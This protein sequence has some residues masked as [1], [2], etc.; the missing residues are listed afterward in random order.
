MLENYL[1][2]GS[3]TLRNILYKHANGL[4]EHQAI[5]AIMSVDEKNREDDIQQVEVSTEIKDNHKTE[6]DT[7]SV[8][9]TKTG[10]TVYFEKSF[11][12]NLN[13]AKEKFG[14]KIVYEFFKASAV[15]KTQAAVRIVLNDPMIS[16][17]VA[18]KAGLEYDPSLIHKRRSKKDPINQIANKIKSGELSQEGFI[19]ELKK[20]LAE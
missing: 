20:K 5:K 18:I 12:A 7:I 3:L 11:G 16:E 14:E 13:E 2:K 10:R 8:T 9:S 4:E 15:I 17:E 19:A 1:E 6:K